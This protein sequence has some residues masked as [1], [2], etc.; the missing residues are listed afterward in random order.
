MAT[1]KKS[2]V[3]NPV[4]FLPFKVTVFDVNK[5]NQIAPIGLSHA[6]GSITFSTPEG[7]L[8]IEFNKWSNDTVVSISLRK[9]SIGKG[10]DH[11]I[12]SGP[13]FDIPVSPTV[14]GS[15]PETSLMKQ[16][17]PNAE[18]TEEQVYYD[19]R[20]GE[21]QIEDDIQR[22]PTEEWFIR[23]TPPHFRR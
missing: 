23:N 22:L 12:F 5:Q 3:G 2:K 17:D 1:L 19:E 21:V 14:K 11:A 4:E 8:H 15:S 6:G 20:S 7:D 18:Q 10:Q 13:L 9:N 16:G